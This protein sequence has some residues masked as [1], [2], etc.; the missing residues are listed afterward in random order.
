MSQTT[1]LDTEAV[2]ASLDALP[3]YIQDTYLSRR[4]KTFKD[5][6]IMGVDQAKVLSFTVMMPEDRNVDVE[7]W[8]QRPIQVKITP[9]GEAPPQKLLDLLREDIMIMVQLFE[10]KVRTTTL[11][12][13]FVRSETVETEEAQPRWERIII[14]LLTESMMLLNII[15]MFMSIFLFMY[16]GF[17]TP[18]VLIALQVLIVLNSDKII[19]ERGTWPVTSDNPT[20]HLLQYHLSVEE[21][22]EFRR[23]HGFEVL[24]DIKKRIHDRTLAAEKSLDF[25][26]VA[27]AF[28]EYGVECKPERASIKTINLYQLI[29]VAAQKFD[30]PIPKV[31]ILNTMMPN[32]AA[33]G[34]SPNRAT[35]LVTTGLLAQLEEEEIYSVLGHEFSHLRGR[36]PLAL[37][38]LG[39]LEYL[40]R[41]YVL[42]SFMYYFP[43][44]YLFISLGLVYFVA[45]VFEARSDLESAV[46]IGNPKALAEGLRKIGF[47]KLYFERVH[48]QRLRGW[49]GWEPHPPAYF[50][51][52]RLDKF[53]PSKQPKDLLVQSAKDCI[54]GFLRALISFSYP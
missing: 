14:R 9:Q 30:V 47:R 35:V 34:P 46:R 28:A 2:R 17:W 33:S 37:F 3:E 16:I 38:T 21:F 24:K 19:M 40:L 54:T 48:A 5:I 11:Y 52:R 39:A 31:T 12:F 15:F 43:L 51:I 42:W 45:K 53:Q 4:K 22:N 13:N 27:E 32:A 1:Y 49:I 7:V 6:K 44:G 26:T 18:V 23:K 29:E 36:D 25:D 10:E 20:V 41:A 8:A 50:R